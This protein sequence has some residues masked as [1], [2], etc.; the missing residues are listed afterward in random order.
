[1][2]TI[3]ICR[4]VAVAAPALI[5]CGCFSYV[6]APIETV[7]AGQDVRVY[8]SRRGMAELPEELEPN[9]PFL[10][11]TLIRREEEHLFIRVPVARVQQGFHSTQI[12]QE[13]SVPTGEI[14]QVQR[15]Q[16]NRAGTGLLVVGTA[17]SATAIV[18]LITK[19]FASREGNPPPIEEIR[20]PLFSLPVRE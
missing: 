20:I 8:M 5:L 6:P 10:T 9:G 18:F 12:G 3:A 15:R 13:I 14:V 16:F 11:G 2:N 1:M 17:A 19:A 7:P 4:Q